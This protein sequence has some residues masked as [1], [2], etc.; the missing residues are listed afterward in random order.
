MILD[1]YRELVL[2]HMFTGTTYAP[3]LLVAGYYVFT[4]A[5]RVS[6]R[7]SVR[8]TSVRPHFVSVR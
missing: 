2:T 8:S 4:L 5:V 7:P 3:G 6:V 1:G